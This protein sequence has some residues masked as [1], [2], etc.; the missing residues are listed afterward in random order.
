[1]EEESISLKSFLLGDPPNKTLSK[2]AA[3]VTTVL[4][5]GGDIRELD[6]RDLSADI[7]QELERMFDIRLTDV[8]ASAWKDYHELTKCA[9]LSKHPANEMISLPMVDQHIETVLRPCLD[10]MIGTRPPIRI[11]FAI[12]CELEFKGLVLKIQDATI[13]AICVGS[14]CAKGSVKCEGITLIRRETKELNL[15]G[16][17]VLTHGIPIQPLRAAA[18]RDIEDWNAAA[19]SFAA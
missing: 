6:W 11:T 15:P 10:V 17:I 4:K 12:T 16:R 13:R 3:A 2:C 18:P 9:D 7:A 19:W 8:L 14:C 1:M 5:A